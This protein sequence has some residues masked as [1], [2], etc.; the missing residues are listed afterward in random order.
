MQIYTVDN[1]SV[2][3]SEGDPILSLTAGLMETTAQRSKHSAHPPP[4]LS[5]ARRLHNPTGTYYPSDTSSAMASVSNNCTPV[6]CNKLATVDSLLS[7]ALVDGHSRTPTPDRCEFKDSTPVVTSEGSDPTS[8]SRPE[9]LRAKSDR[10]RPAENAKS[11]ECGDEKTREI[12]VLSRPLVKG[13]YSSDLSSLLSNF[14]SFWSGSRS[15]AATVSTAGG[16]KVPMSCIPPARSHWAVQVG[17]IVH[18]LEREEDGSVIYKHRDFIL[19]EWST[20]FHVGETILTDEQLV[21]KGACLIETLPPRYHPVGN[22]CQIFAFKFLHIILHGSRRQI[23]A[24]TTGV[25]TGATWIAQLGEFLSLS[26]SPLVTAA[27]MACRGIS[28]ALHVAD[29]SYL[30]ERGEEAKTED[31]EFFNLWA[32]SGWEHL[33]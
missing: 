25:R 31:N 8:Q 11:A 13:G 15:S 28:V 23:T 26:G 1:L 19:H 14:N 9:T 4:Y 5:T 18:E 21:R 2:H 7:A 33:H 3:S 16:S 20:S 24:L 29:G 17:D 32:R 22:N 27:G 12:Y 10:S 30:Y 6:A